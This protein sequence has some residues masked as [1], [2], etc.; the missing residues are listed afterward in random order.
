MA[1]RLPE[2]PPVLAGLHHVRALGRGGFADVFLFEQDMPR[3]QVAVKV[4]HHGVVNE[5][6]RRM[7]NAEADVMARLGAHPSIVT[8]YDASISAD[9]RPYLVMELCPRSMGSRYRTEVIAVPEVL[10][11]GVRIA[12][13]LETAVREGI[14]HRDIKPANILISAFGTP[15]L[16]DFGIAT[17]LSGRGQE[18]LPAMSVPW[19]APEVVEDR[20]P[21]TVASE[22]WA[23]GATLY[24]LLAGRTPFEVDDPSQNTRERLIARISRAR[25]RAI[26][27][28]D[29]P[30]PLEGLLRRTME[31][32]PARRPARL[33]DV[34]RELQRVQAGLGIT[35]TALEV[36]EQGWSAVAGA[37]DLDDGAARGPVVSTVPHESRRPRAAPAASGADIGT[38]GRAP[39]DDD[40]LSP[41]GPRRRHVA[42]IAVATGAVLLG[43]GALV[44]SVVIGGL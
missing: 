41:R 11:T 3:R 43:V 42:L 12:S 31:R 21:G 14:L 38:G 33:V 9:G 6:V 19:S 8:V 18:L 27:R 30:E 24:T 2:R 25:Y 40:I 36:A 22:V 34:A 13:A 16:A 44:A 17:A 5:D 4:L 7:F 28:R 35:P 32:D 23:L 26:G 29:V 20:T 1:T 10:D 39:A 37:L 15:V